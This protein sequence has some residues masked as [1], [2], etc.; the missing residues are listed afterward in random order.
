M[1][2]QDHSYSRLVTVL[3]VSLPLI[4]LGILST[5]FLLARKPDP[6][7]TLPFVTDGV[8]TF[9]GQ[10][11]ITRPNFAGVTEDGAAISLKA[12]FVRPAEGE[13][14]ALEAGGLS[15]RIETPGGGLVA[16]IGDEGSIDLTNQTASLLGSVGIETSTGYSITTEGF[17]VDLARTD[18]VTQGS[19]VARTPVGELSA[20]AFLVQ[21]S[22]TGRHVL[23]FNEGV[24][25]IY[26]PTTDK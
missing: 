2:I 24:K 11:Q 8:D 21:V 25:L 9:A 1:A 20:G 4:A 12:D 19:V 17:R 7:T 23:I 6:T 18:A 16:V 10:Q 26:D 13:S 14:T 3:K 22:T 15:A 5:L